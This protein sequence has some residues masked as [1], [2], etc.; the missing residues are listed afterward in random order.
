ML[1][2][3]PAIDRSV[4]VSCAGVITTGADLDDIGQLACLHEVIGVVIVACAEL[5]L[6]VVSP[7]MN[8]P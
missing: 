3:T 2:I 6:G 1:I 8:R 4:G 7:A 5:T